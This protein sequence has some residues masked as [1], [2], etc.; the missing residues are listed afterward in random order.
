[1]AIIR[2]RGAAMTCGPQVL[3]GSRDG[4]LKSRENATCIVYDVTDASE[5]PSWSVATPAKL[6][7]CQMPA[8][9]F[10]SSP[11]NL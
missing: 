8:N 9:G 11:S 7:R 3:I 1:M 4:K 5:P 10:R 6:F 2:Q